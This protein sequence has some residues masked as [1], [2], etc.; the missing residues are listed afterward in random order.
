MA[1]RKKR[2]VRT[3]KKKKK[4]LELVVLG[5]A[6]VFIGIGTLLPLYFPGPIL[7][8]DWGVLGWGLIL[9]GILLK[10]ATKTKK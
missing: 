5:K 2:A 4:E 7:G 10:L 8:Q 3:V 6:L 1:R 9:L